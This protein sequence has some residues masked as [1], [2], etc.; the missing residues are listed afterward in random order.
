MDF[1]LTDEQQ[2]R[3]AHVR[4]FAEERLGAAAGE[5]GMG[6][7]RER[8][9]EAGEFGLTGLPVPAQWGGNGLG[10]LDTIL[11]IEALGRGCQDMGLVFSLCAHLFAG[12]VPV[13]RHGSDA[14]HQQ[15]LPDLAKGRT[16]VANAIT[17][18]DSGS[19]AYAM[20]ARAERKGEGYVLNALKCFVTNAP[21]AD[22]ILVY[23][24][25]R[26]EHGYLG[27]SAFLVDAATAG[28]RVTPEGEKTGLASSPW[29]TLYLD[30]CYVPQSC[31][32][33]AEGAGGPIFHDSM[34]WE[35]CCLFA[36][37][38]G[39]MER[40]LEQ[41]IAHAR[42]RHQYGRPIGR[43]QAVSERI[44]NF[45]LRLET[46]RL[47]LYRAGWLYDQGRPCEV[48]IAQSKL[49]IS[50][51]AVQCGLD[52]VQIF[53]ASGVIRDTGVDRLLLDALPA[54]IF[55]GTSEIQKEV[56]ARH[57]GLRK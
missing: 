4:R 52:A 29:G 1:D 46:A 53:G 3:I 44:V 2:Q 38:V 37:Y 33:G 35:R 14:Q 6:F 19:D 34:T 13:W 23:A 16:I 30:D 56:L 45:Q 32:L 12:T 27:I 10:A 49:W 26:P 28:V 39:A 5:A 54:R 47:L 36:A 57:L 15:Y 51:C 11:A 40:V 31:R 43:N 41:C 42:Q 50:E 7:D 22:L 17:E 21:V 18:P 20:Q 8:W 55:S 9:N 24:R 48:A 25:T